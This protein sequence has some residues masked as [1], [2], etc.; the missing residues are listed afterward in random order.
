MR[1]QV[2]E[3]P[4]SSGGCGAEDGLGRNGAADVKGGDLK[5]GI[6]GEIDGGGRTQGGGVQSELFRRE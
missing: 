6:A 1:G 5:L 2:N 4:L 3:S